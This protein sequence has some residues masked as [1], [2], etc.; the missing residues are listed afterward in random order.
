MNDQ[1]T[2]WFKNEIFSGLKMDDVDPL[3][4]MPPPNQRPAP[5]WKIVVIFGSG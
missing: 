4:M 2:N 3:N 5:G 1:L